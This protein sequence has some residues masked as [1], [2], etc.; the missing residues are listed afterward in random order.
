MADAPGGVITLSDGRM[1][2]GV[3]RVDDSVRR[4]ASDSSKFVAAL[5]KIFEQQKFD[6]APGI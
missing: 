6:G 2:N 3:V 1:T 5:L 4:P